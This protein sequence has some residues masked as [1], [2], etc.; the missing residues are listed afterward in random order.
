MYGNTYELWSCRW[1]WGCIA[2]DAHT[3]ARCNINGET[4]Q[5]ERAGRQTV[6]LQTTETRQSGRTRKSSGLA[7]AR[8]VGGLP[9]RDERVEHAL[10]ALGDEG[11]GGI[12]DR[13]RA[14]DLAQ[15]RVVC[16]GL[17]RRCTRVSRTMS[18]RTRSR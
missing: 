13:R 11:Y 18:W 1:R 5:D 14:I 3:H 6:W 10:L 9:A 8:V 2:T 15:A 7:G 12:D 16:A 17:F 4:R